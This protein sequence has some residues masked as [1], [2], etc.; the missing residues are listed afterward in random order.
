MLFIKIIRKYV[1]ILAHYKSCSSSCNII[2][3]TC[4]NQL[5]LTFALS[6]INPLFNAA[7]KITFNQSP[8]ILSIGPKAASFSKNFPYMIRLAGIQ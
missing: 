1:I 2:I 3:L 8:S 5:L 6:V 7:E 4:L